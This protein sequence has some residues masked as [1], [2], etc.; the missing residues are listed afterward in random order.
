M[1]S[2]NMEGKKKVHPKHIY[3]LLLREESSEV[4][5]SSYKSFTK[6]LAN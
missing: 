3:M 1:Q 5:T 2:L 6:N 4:A